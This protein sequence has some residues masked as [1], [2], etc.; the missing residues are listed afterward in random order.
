MKTKLLLF[1]SGLLFT[2]ISAFS[3][4]TAGNV[5][6]YRYGDGGAYTNGNLAPTFLDEYTPA[7]VLVKTRAIPTVTS[8]LNKGLTG[9]LKLGTGFYQQEGMSTLSQDGK[10]ITIFGYNA[11]VGTTVPTTTDGL[12][13]GVVAAD[14]SYNSTTTLS[15]D[16]TLGL[17]APR[18]AIVDGT[19]IW[20]NGFRNGVQYATIGGTTSAQ[21]N[22]TGQNSPRTLSIFN[23]NLTVPIG[24]SGTLSYQTPL[25]TGS[26]AAFST[27]ILSGT[28]TTNQVV[29]FSLGNR[30]V[31]YTADDA[32]NQIRRFNTNTAGDTWI[33]LGT[34][35]TTTPQL[36]LVKSIT[37]VANVVGANTE[38]TI[39]ITTWGNDGSGTESSKLLTFK[40]T[41]L[42]P[43]AG[44]SAPTA[45][46]ALAT[47]ATATAGTVFRSVTM[48]PQG[49]TAIGTATLPVSLTSFTGKKDNES[50]KLDWTTASEK[51]NSHFDI[52]RSVDGKKFSSIGTMK[53]GGNSD[54][55]LNYSFADTNPLS[56]TNYYQL[57]QFDFDGNS[58]KS[59]IVAVE[60]G[61]KAADMTIY[62]NQSSNEV[63]LNIF[64][65]NKTSG[66]IN[67]FDLAGKRVFN[68]TV[69]LEKGYN[70][71]SLSVVLKSGLFVA[72]LQTASETISKKFTN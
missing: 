13:V 17:G 11:A 44:P 52:T 4:F 23:N 6:V 48:A 55:A 16:A 72:T 12:V 67:I 45:T 69:E 32:N 26:A 3:Q 58:A 9:L 30:L 14:L 47:L 50:I 65:A 29:T 63:K 8:G 62:A 39:F 51:N 7:G 25:P 43:S 68:K 40:D 70:N 57:N 59:N 5:V 37:G 49:S 66:T 19:N 24:S 71:I 64:S 35:L 33:A 1:I 56:G 20:A 60:S 27:R 42:T 15:N 10:Y 36:T 28:P 61:L 21:V 53:G 38:I 46:T 2:S 31:I 54:A 22:T 18:S 41:Y 34:N